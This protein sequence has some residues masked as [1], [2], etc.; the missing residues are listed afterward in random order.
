MKAS[1]HS[2]S[3]RLASLGLSKQAIDD[4]LPTV[5]FMSLKQGD[6][7][8]H[9]GDPCK[10]F[11]L[12]LSGSLH[13]N[14]T[15][16]SGREM[17]LYTVEPGELC[18]QTFQ[19]LATGAPYSA[20][21]HV[22]A[23]MDALVLPAQKFKALMSE[24]QAFRDFLLRIVANRFSSLTGLIEDVASVSVSARLARYLLSHSHDDILSA[25]QDAIAVEVSASREAVSRILNLWKQQ[26]II[27]LA[28]GTV[29]ILNKSALYTMAP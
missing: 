13:V 7:V 11:M 23:D 17:L 5:S 19:C 9:G 8:F 1:E 21:G 18:V 15:T 27:D 2:V 4:L 14:L 26:R 22:V 25:T 3:D 28:R 24:S 6:I 16:A 29:K 10:H 12:P 20:E